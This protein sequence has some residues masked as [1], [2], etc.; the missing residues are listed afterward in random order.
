MD[1]HFSH[2][3]KD[4]LRQPERLEALGRDNVVDRA[5]AGIKARS[6]LDIGVGSG[7]FAELFHDAGLSVTGLDDSMSMLFEARRYV[8]AAAYCQAKAESP[9]F[10]SDA[11]DLAFMA[12]LLHEVDDPAAV[13]AAT[14]TI[15]RKRIVVLEWPYETSAFGPP[16]EHR[17]DRGAIE[18]AARQAG[19][20][21]TGVHRVAR[22]ELFLFERE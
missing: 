5:L 16:I 11:F 13:L 3:N 19:L 18:R 7:V 20:R 14:K 8:P 22:M 21:I 15:C 2:E 17:L 10:R 12:L 6:V 9:P 4:R 1:K